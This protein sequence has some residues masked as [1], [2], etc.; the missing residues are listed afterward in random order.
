MPALKNARA[1]LT[2]RPLDT[3]QT[4]LIQH[5]ASNISVDYEDGQAVA[6]AFTLEVEGRSLSFR[7]PARIQNVAHKLYGRK[8]L[9]ATMKKQAY[10][11]AWACIRDWVTAQMA[12]ID[13]GMVKMEEVFLPY[14]LAAN[15]QTVYEAFEQKQF[16]LERPHATS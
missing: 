7:L 16:L 4:C 3:I 9:T 14:L 5:K 11:T 6:L 10:V 1:R 2:T 15:G 13:I 12:L 8:A